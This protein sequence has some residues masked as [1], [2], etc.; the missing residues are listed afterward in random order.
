MSELVFFD[1]DNTL[2]SGQTQE[3][4]I[5]YLFKCGRISFW[6][7]LKLYFWFLLYRLGLIRDTIKIR[8][9]TFKL[10]SGWDNEETKQLLEDFFNREIK[11]KIFPQAIEIINS[12]Q[13][14]G[15][16]VVLLSASLKPLIEIIGKWFNITDV[17]AVELE[18]KN[19][20]YTGKILGSVVYG[21]QKVEALKN[22]IN[23]YNPERLIAYADH[24]S[25][26]ELLRFVS[27]PHVVNPDK[28]ILVIAK[29]NN[30]PIH[31]FKL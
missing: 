26:L 1:V 13:K 18:T 28:K 29:K 11:E 31:Y 7:L 15:R 2:V 5:K 27:E 23:R 16:R 8:E 4:L 9:K 19:K 12:Y 14:E 17:V 24:Y 22:I 25:D 6:F 20:K 10:V 30:W 21:Q 3:Y